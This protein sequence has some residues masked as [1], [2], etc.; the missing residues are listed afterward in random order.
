VLYELGNDREKLK[1]AFSLMMEQDQ[2]T[3]IYYGT[4]IGMNQSQG[5]KEFAKHGDLQAREPMK[6]NNQDEELLEFFRE[7]IC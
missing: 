6:W 1:K 3:V 7:K 5:M 4:E 2:P